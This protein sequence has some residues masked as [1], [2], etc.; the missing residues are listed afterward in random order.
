VLS[1]IA[2]AEPAALLMKLDS[3][4]DLTPPFSASTLGE[5]QRSGVA[6]HVTVDFGGASHPGKVRPNNEDHYLVARMDRV[7]QTLK[8]NL[9]SGSVPEQQTE[10]AYG[11][12]IADGMGGHAAGEVASRTAIVTLVELILRTPDLILRLDKRLTDQALRRL[13]QRFQEIK[14]ALM[15]QVE[16]DPKLYGMGTTMTLACSLGVDLLIAH[17]GDSRAYLYRQGQLQRLT[18]DQT[19]AQFLADTG[20]ISLEEV[21]THPMRHVLT[22]ALGTKGGRTKVDLRGMRLIDA[23]QVLLCTDGLTEM[24]PDNKIADILA[25]GGSSTDAC[26]ALIEQ[27]LAA[28]GKDNVTVVLARYSIAPR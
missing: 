19:M 26:A 14:S 25:R 28:G 10:T 11:L 13:D 27:A 9:P 3:D 23:D 2:Q 5:A 15:D 16:A 21:A 4:T 24:V 17:V 12:L 6:A 8:T 18:R 20:V 1:Y 7:M 22:G